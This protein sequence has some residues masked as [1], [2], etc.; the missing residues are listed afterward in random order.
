MIAYLVQGLTLG[1][2]AAAQPGPFQ[3]YLLS[4]ALKNGWRRS[5]LLAFVPLVSD[6]PIIALVLFVLTQMPGW[7]IRAL[8]VGGGL[9]LLY[10]AWGAFSALRAARAIAPDETAARRTFAQAVVMNLL[11]PNPYLFWGLIG[12]PLVLGGWS[13]SPAAGLSF[14]AA[15]YLTIVAGVAALILLFG[16]AQHLGVTVT[17]A[18]TALSAL[19]LFLFGLYQLWQG[20]FIN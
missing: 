12:G 14:M 20:V 7:L 13:L 16:S 8:R 9:F 1:F 11:N 2:A 4:Q 15:F 19:A 5:L 18:L 3:A 6:G 10:L 17:R